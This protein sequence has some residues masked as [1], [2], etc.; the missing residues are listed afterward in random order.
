MECGTWLLSIQCAHISISQ[1]VLS[2]RV[3]STRGT[4]SYIY[5]VKMSEDYTLSYIPTIVKVLYDMP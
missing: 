3:V 2:I 5:A 1:D 4:S